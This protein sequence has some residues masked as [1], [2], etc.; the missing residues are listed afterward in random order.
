MRLAES[1]LDLVRAMGATAA[2]LHFQ[3]LGSRAESISVEVGFDPALAK[4]YDEHCHQVNILLKRAAP[5][6]T[7]GNIVTNPQ[8]CEDSTLARSEYYD[9]FLRPQDL[10]RR[11]DRSQLRAALLDV[12]LPAQAR[13]SISGG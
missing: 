3:D 4:S 13:R 11:N 9:G 7:P 1:A 5:F 8:I 2:A 10:R 12:D 6:L